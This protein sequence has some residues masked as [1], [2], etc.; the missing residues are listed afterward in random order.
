MGAR[1]E[2][3]GKVYVKTGPI[4]AT[5]EEGGQ[6]MIPRYAV[7]RPLDGPV[8]VPSPRVPRIL[9]EATVLSAFEPF[10]QACVGVLEGAVEDDG[11]LDGARRELSLARDRFLAALGNGD[12]AGTPAGAQE[13]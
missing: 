5:S 7:L 10:Y 1:F 8:P 9:D 6:R 12:S 11:R 3:Q 4:A 13:K 2:F